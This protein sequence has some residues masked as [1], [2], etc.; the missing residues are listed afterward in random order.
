MIF[1]DKALATRIGFMRESSRASL[2]AGGLGLLDRT[3]VT[4]L[5][6]TVE[7]GWEDRAQFDLSLSVIASD[8]EIICSILGVD[9]IGE[10]QIGG[11]EKLPIIIDVDRPTS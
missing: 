7:A 5:S 11:S 4:D 3:P 1:F 8:Q 6:E 9:I 10:F 2:L